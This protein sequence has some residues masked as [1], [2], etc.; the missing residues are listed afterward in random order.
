MPQPDRAREDR[1]T[2]VSVS[3]AAANGA[4]PCERFADGLVTDVMDGSLDRAARPVVLAHLVHCEA[5]SA[6]LA[7]M[8][9]VVRLLGRVPTLLEA[10]A[11]ADL[12]V[13]ET[14]LPLLALRRLDPAPG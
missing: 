6:L 11:P 12:V 13:L 14:C 5:C 1:A 2:G 3:L 4:S 10:D 7:R 8:R 9:S